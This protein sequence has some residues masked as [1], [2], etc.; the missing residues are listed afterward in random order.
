MSEETTRRFDLWQNYMRDVP[1]PQDFLDF[2][3]YWMI[4]AALQRRVWLQDVDKPLFPNLY[5]L[6]IAPPGIGKGHTI[7]PISE[8]LRH[9][10]LNSINKPLTDGPAP[11]SKEEAGA[12]IMMQKLQEQM[13]ALNAKSNKKARTPLLFPCSP[14]DITYEELVHQIA[15][16]TRRLNVDACDMAKSGSYSHCSLAMMLEEM[17]TL[18][19][20]QSEKAMKFLLKAFDCGDYE[21][22]TKTQGDDI[23]R[24]CCVNLLAGTTPSQIKDMVDVQIVGDGFTSRCII[25]YA[26]CERFATFGIG[27]RNDEQRTAKLEILEHLKNLSKV[28]GN[29]E[30]EKDTFDYLHEYFVSGKHRTS[31]AE[32]LQPYFQR[33]N[34]H[35][36]KLAT[37]IHFAE[38]DIIYKDSR[39]LFDNKLR[40]WEAQRAV[41]MLEQAEPRMITALQFKEKNPIADTTKRIVR[42]LSS[43]K[44]LNKQ[45]LL[46]MLW[47]ILPNGMIS[48]DEALNYLLTANIVEYKNNKYKLK[49]E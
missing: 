3:F 17:A 23:V 34:I 15:F 42:S 14:D 31:S 7:N 39:P 36:P 10:K 29:L 9:H 28:F 2:G 27:K 24:R 1:A 40:L 46:V 26:E 6:L 13:D 21:Y 41:K 33:K 19:K 22:A 32:I 18:F 43:A 16:H 4:S 45:Q 37:A 12:F 48:L 30:Y 11:K 25:L 5:I 47:D 38:A 20:R 49:E 35:V 44:E 8:F